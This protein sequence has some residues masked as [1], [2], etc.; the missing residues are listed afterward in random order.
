MNPDKIPF[1]LNVP[2]DLMEKLKDA[3]AKESRTI[4]SQINVMLI[5]QFES[6]QSSLQK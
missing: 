6:Q 4:T 1:K 3:A 5:R 2:T